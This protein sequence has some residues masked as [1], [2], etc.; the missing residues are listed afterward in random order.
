MCSRCVLAANVDPGLEAR[1]GETY[2]EGWTV[3]DYQKIGARFLATR[4]SALLSDHMGLGKTAQALLAIPENAPVV[5]VCPSQVKSVWLREAAT[6][7]P[8]IEARVIAGRN[9]WTAPLNGEIVILNYAI[10][11]P[12]EVNCATCDHPGGGHSRREGC[13]D[14]ECGCDAFRVPAPTSAAVRDALGLLPSTVLIADEVHK[15]KTLS[16]TRTQRLRYLSAGCDR[17]WGLTA[18]PVMNHPR[19][20]W[21]IYNVLGLARAAFPGGAREFDA[22]AEFYDRYRAATHEVEKTFTERRAR[23]ELGRTADMVGLEL[24]E[25]LFQKRVVEI[26][27]GARAAIEG[28]L[29]HALAA[30]KVAGEIRRGALK[31]EDAQARQAEL[32]L[33]SHTTEDVEEL[34]EAVLN[35]NDWADIAPQLATL[36]KALAMAKI[37]AA[38]EYAKECADAGEPLV[39][40]SAHVAPVEALAGVKGWVS[41]RKANKRTQAIADFQAG[42]LA[43]VAGTIRGSS[44]G[45]TLTRGRLLMFVDSDWTPEAN[46]QALKRIHR[47][48]QTRGC[49]ITSLVADHEVDRYVARVVQR[50]LGMVQSLSRRG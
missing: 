25:L 38:I 31:E 7:R 24:P 13:K 21:S 43:G 44:E 32:A 19:E 22:L 20:L 39:A 28:A 23:V 35:T 33:T 48:G 36:R 49:L 18:S 1:L 14:P 27:T 3:S 17:V 29:S 2:G 16:T 10:L 5:V 6:W 30:R 4:W 11:P 34:L 26:S 40:F 9:G 15:A 47:I 45:I 8:A 46:M 12:I 37:P 41:L 42:K 50:K